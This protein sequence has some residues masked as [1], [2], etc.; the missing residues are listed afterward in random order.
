MLFQRNISE[1]RSENNQHPSS[2]AACALIV[3]A[4]GRTTFVE[5]AVYNTACV[6]NIICITISFCDLETM[7]AN[8]KRLGYIFLESPCDSQACKKNGKCKNI[9][10]DF[11]CKCPRYFKGKR[12]QIKSKNCTLA[13]RYSLLLCFYF[14]RA[15]SC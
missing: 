11:K 8:E 3:Y 15:R 4:F 7:G 14:T 10:K 9:G 5:I 2:L 6:G 12:C 13:S 1:L